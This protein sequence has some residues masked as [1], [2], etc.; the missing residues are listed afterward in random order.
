MKEKDVNVT[1]NVNVWVNGVE[2]TTPPE[3]ETEDTDPTEE[4]PTGNP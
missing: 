2:Q 3:P 1:V 4:D